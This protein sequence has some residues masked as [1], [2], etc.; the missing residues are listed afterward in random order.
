VASFAAFALE[1]GFWAQEGGFLEIGL[2]FGG[3]DLVDSSR[4]NCWEILIYFVTK[5]WITNFI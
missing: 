1:V 4:E 2:V 5:G 3:I